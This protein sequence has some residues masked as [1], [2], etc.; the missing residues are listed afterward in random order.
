M[1]EMGGSGPLLRRPVLHLDR[2]VAVLSDAAAQAGPG[3]GWLSPGEQSRLQAMSHPQRADTFLAGRWLLRRACSAW[4]G[5]PPE[6]WQFDVPHGQPPR[7][8]RTP[9]FAADAPVPLVSLSH[10]GDFVACTVSVVPVGVD[11]EAAG[12]PRDH[13][14]L[15]RRVLDA[16]ER[17]AYEALPEPDRLPHFLCR[18]TLKE[19]WGKYSG[20]RLGLVLLPRIGTRPAQPGEA[21]A[22]VWQGACLTLATCGVADPDVQDHSDLLAGLARQPWRVVRPSS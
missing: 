10:S 5:L 15:A 20:E 1:G 22:A 12:I 9:G 16:H 7:A 6:A 18:W 4:T 11:I 21:D 19:A 2:V 13:A 14:R 17:Q 3:H 8:T